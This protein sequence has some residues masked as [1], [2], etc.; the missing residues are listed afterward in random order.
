MLVLS[1]PENLYKLLQDCRM[2]AITS[3]C[4][5]GRIVEVAVDFAF[6]FVIAVFSTESCR[7]NRASEV[8]NVVLV[9]E[10]CDIGASQSTSAI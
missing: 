8:I 1:V 7:T 9:V 2:A 5:S 4:E 6:V 10:S 3:L